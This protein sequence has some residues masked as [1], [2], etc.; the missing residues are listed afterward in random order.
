M[1]G[2]VAF[3]DINPQ[4]VQ[5]ASER[6]GSDRAAGYVADVTDA[7]AVAKVVAQAATDFGGNIDAIVNCAGIAKPIVAAEGADAD[8][9]RM[10]DVH[11]NGAMR[12]CR[13]AFPYLKTSGRGSIVNISSVA[14]TF[15]LPGRTNYSAAKAGIEGLTR[16][17]AVEW[18]PEVRV[19][20]V[21]PGYVQTPMIDELVAAGKLD[22]AP[23]LARTPMARFCD[24]DEIAAVVCFLA[25]GLSSFVTGQTITVDGGLTVDGNWYGSTQR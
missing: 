21:A 4:A 24:P 6:L 3:V 19:N 20:A 13:A 17:L 23:I 10:I 16:G 25:S 22:P 14:G 5:Q 15:G 8:W 7:E 2:R 18:A 12:V 9:T 11:L 1:G